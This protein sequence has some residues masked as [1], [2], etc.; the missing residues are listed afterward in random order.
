MT[1]LTRGLSKWGVLKPKIH[2]LHFI[3]LVFTFYD[4]KFKFHKVISH[5]SHL[6]KPIKFRVLFKKFAYGLICCPVRIVLNNDFKFNFICKQKWELKEG[7]KESVLSHICSVVAWELQWEIN[8]N[9]FVMF[10]SLSK[11]IAPFI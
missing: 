8:G 1:G 7:R 9:W 11:H 6:I 3:H 4:L 5:K 2:Q 10:F